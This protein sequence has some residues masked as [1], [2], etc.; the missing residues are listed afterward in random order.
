M[1]KKYTVFVSAS[2]LWLVM[3][4]GIAVHA[5]DKAEKEA[6]APAAALPA[7]PD[8]VRD[9]VVCLLPELYHRN[10]N[11]TFWLLTRL[12]DEVPPEKL[13]ITMTFHNGTVSGYS[14]CNS[15]AG[16]FVNPNDTLFG[17]KDI[18]TTQRKCEEAVCP[19]FVDGGNWEEKYLAAL[20]NMAK[21]DKSDNELKLFDGEGKLVMVFRSLK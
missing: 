9:G 11:S 4:S 3:G 7:T 14:G 21:L 8:A 10:L 20:P 18:E 13:A 19:T 15:Y 2:V 1:L 12:N 16:T 5:E 6:A 17:V